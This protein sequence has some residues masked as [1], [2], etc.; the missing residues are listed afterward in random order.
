MK[1]IVML[2]CLMVCLIFTPLNVLANNTVGV[3]AGTIGAVFSAI[4]LGLMQGR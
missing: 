3:I 1:K 2:I 4:A